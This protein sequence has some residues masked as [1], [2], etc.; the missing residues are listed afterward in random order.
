[1]LNIEEDTYKTLCLDLRRAIA[2]SGTASPAI[3]WTNY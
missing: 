2:Q 3:V 1:L